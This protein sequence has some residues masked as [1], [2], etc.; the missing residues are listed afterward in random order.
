VGVRGSEDKLPRAR[1]LAACFDGLL[2]VSSLP[3]AFAEGLNAR[4][5]HFVTNSLTL[6]QHLK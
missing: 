3:H 6:L 1:E 4:T 5:L 2:A